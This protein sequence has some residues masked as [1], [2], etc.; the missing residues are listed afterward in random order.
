MKEKFAVVKSSYIDQDGQTVEGYDDSEH[1]TEADALAK[2]KTLDT[3]WFYIERRVW[4]HI[5]DGI[6]DWRSDDHYNGHYED[7]KW[8]YD[9][10]EA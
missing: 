8:I 7:K 1:K 3:D 9:F 6:Y 10:D 5:A 2:L 4:E